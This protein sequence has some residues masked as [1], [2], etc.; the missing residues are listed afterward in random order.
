MTRQRKNESDRT[1]VKF[2]PNFVDERLELRLL[3]LGFSIGR[4]HERLQPLGLLLQALHRPQDVV[5]G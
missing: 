3:G 1:H 4:G 5:Q 2:L